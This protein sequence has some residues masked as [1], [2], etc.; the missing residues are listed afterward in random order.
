MGEAPLRN[1]HDDGIIIDSTVGQMFC[2]A[3]LWGKL[4]SQIKF[5]NEEDEEIWERG[6]EAQLWERGLTRMRSRWSKTWGLSQAQ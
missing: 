4:R 6:L 3:N 5:G 2:K 1:V